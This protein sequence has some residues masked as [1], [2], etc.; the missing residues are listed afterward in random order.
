MKKLIYSILTLASF[1]VFVSC[2]GSENKDSKEVAKENNEAK[3]E[4]TKIE[5]D[6]KFA[7]NAAD[8]G[9]LEVQLGKL[10]QTNGVSQSVKDLGKMMESDHAKANDELKSLA[11]QKNIT[12]PASLSEKHQKTYDDL[13]AKKGA[14]FDKAYADA[15]VSDH[16]DDI[17][18]FKKE[19]DKGKDADIKSWAA[20]KVP[21]LEHHLEMSKATKDAVNK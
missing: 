11:A 1:S 19:A 4:D 13:A 20:G 5:D 15:M 7:V 9:M 2:G 12:L 16:N 18:E 10:A 21:V 8:G 3:F 17:D 6:T 14:D